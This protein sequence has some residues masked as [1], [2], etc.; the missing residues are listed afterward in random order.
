MT[1][2]KPAA[3]GPV[4]NEVAKMVCFYDVNPFKSFDEA[5]D[6]NPEGFRVT[7]VLASRK[8]GKGIAAAGVI[9]MKMYRVDRIAP[10][11]VVRTLVREWTADTEGLRTFRSG[12]LGEGYKLDFCWA[13]ED[14]VLGREVEF[15]PSFEGPDGCVVRGQTKAQHV[16]VHKT[17]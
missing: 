6:P 9:H 10:D 2:T 12:A 17:P 11:K 8:T 15:V 13:K 16:P 7:V 14:D 3:P 5:G 4:P 1:P